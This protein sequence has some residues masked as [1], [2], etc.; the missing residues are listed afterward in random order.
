MPSRFPGVDPYLESQW[1]WPD[2]HATFIVYLV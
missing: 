1:F 2:F